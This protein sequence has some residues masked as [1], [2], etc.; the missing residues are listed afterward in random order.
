MSQGIEKNA[1]IFRKEKATA[2]KKAHKEITLWAVQ[3]LDATY[4]CGWETRL[5]KMLWKRAGDELSIAH[6]AGA[7]G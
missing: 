1:L 5:C 7:L 4:A 3:G 2:M 6:N